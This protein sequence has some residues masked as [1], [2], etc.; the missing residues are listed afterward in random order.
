[1]NEA[2]IADELEIQNSCSLKLNGEMFYLGGGTDKNQGTESTQRCSLILISKSD[3]DKF[4]KSS[5]D[6]LR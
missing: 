5:Y 2:V 1:M 6:E 3:L 4:Q